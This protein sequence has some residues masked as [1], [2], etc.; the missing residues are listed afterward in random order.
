MS[1]DRRTFLLGAVSTAAL[2][3]S[4]GR[5]IAGD[6]N[7]GEISNLSGMRDYSKLSPDLQMLLK[8]QENATQAA[9]DYQG[10]VR[11]LGN[12]PIIQAM[13]SGNRS[14]FNHLMEWHAF[15]LDLSAI[16]HTTIAG[17]NNPT[18][19]EQ[20]GPVATARAFAIFHLA[21]YEAVNTIFQEHKSYRGVRAKIL[22]DVGKSPSEVSP[23]T[24]SV[25]AALA[26][27][28][29]GTLTAL[30]KN[31][32]ALT[33]ALFDTMVTLL[34]PATP[35]AIVLGTAIGQAA[36]SEV[37]AT[38]QYNPA[39]GV[40]LDG[41]RGISGISSLSIE[42]TYA[43]LQ[44]EGILPANPTTIDWQIDPMVPNNIALGGHWSQVTPFVLTPGNVP[45][46]PPFP[47][48]TSAT[49]K[50]N[51]DDVRAQGGDATPP[52]I[53]P[54][55]PTG[56]IRTGAA[57][58][59]I[60]LPLD[61]NNHTFVGAF[62]GY[63]ATALLCAPP[64]EYNMNATSVA[65]SERT[66]TDTDTMAMYL[67]L[68]NIA[69]ADAGIA[70]WTTKYKYHIA[71]P[72]SYI[73]VTDPEKVVLGTKNKN[74]TPLGAPDSNGPVTSSNF[75]PP[76][77][78]YVSGHATFGGALF[79]TMRRFFDTAKTGEPSYHYVS[80]EYNG[81]N[82]DPLGNVRP[83]VVRNFPSLTF[84]ETENARSRIYNGVHWQIDGL[85]GI[86]I[87]NQV[88]DFVFENAFTS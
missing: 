81:I 13:K 38:R 73:R 27:A 76:F 11:Y 79:Q 17:T 32:L 44:T 35:Q 84:A 50:A 9:P 48:V 2:T 64:R 74:W 68:I 5:S 46:P 63:D 8:A 25:S 39:P 6:A 56:T 60:G 37:L 21:L 18:F 67:A 30:Y 52:N 10:F 65:L 23:E 15:I 7:K 31:K 62:W 3:V 72:V 70:A 57:P 16:D 88:G 47:D 41:S 22:A 51:Y 75:S 42:P 77:P 49:F 34:P 36:A 40:F 26:Y 82:R 55:F 33:I 53:P 61:A 45:I 87:G 80:D 20:F 83:L 66:I 24:A 78:A 4:R 12:L 86:A 28:A 54:R 58:D 29:L 85:M 43:Q 1:F 19:A 69:M 59:G 14:D 71:R